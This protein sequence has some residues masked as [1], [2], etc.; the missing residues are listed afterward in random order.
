MEVPEWIQAARTHCEEGMAQRSVAGDVWTRD[1]SPE[2]ETLLEACADGAEITLDGEDGLEFPIILADRLPVYDNCDPYH[3]SLQ[4]NALCSLCHRGV[5]EAAGDGDR[6][7]LT[8]IARDRGH[9][10]RARHLG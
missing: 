7:Y 9:Q 6:F 1:V 5:V 8:D 3:M 2:E 4:W 10:V